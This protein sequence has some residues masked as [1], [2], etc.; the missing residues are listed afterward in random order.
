MRETMSAL[1]Q[2]VIRA[3]KEV[4]SPAAVRLLFEPVFALLGR[5]RGKSLKPEEIYDPAGLPTP[6]ETEDYDW[7]DS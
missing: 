2:A 3:G 5:R 4:V 1:R 6:E 7:C